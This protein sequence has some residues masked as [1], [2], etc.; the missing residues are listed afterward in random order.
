MKPSK[1]KSVLNNNFKWADLENVNKS[2][3]KISYGRK[4]K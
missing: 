1:I 4:N 3:T 2:I